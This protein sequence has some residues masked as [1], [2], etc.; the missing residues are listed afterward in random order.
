MCLRGNWDFTM[1]RREALRLLAAG[2]ALPLAPHGLLSPLLEARALLG[3]PHAPRT[4]NP[5]Q[6]ATVKLMAETILPKTDTP[7]ASDV[8]AAEFIDLILTEWSADDERSQ[9]ISGLSGVD[10][11]ARALF[12]KDF[13]DCS[14]D[15]QCDILTALG[16]AMTEQARVHDHSTRNRRSMPQPGESFY[17][18][19]RRL[20]MIAYYT[21]EAGA[22]AELKFEII[23][24]H[25]D[26]C[27]EIQTAK[28]PE[29]Q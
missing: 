26:G 11:R 24:D 29:S 18:M 12:G 7:G 23:P 15:K 1:N 3:T 2:T 20:T 9:F 17:L 6:V 8:G 5:H 21:S 28:P 4:L 14:A 10:V 22:T 19:L 27:A 16:E 13:V 25:Y